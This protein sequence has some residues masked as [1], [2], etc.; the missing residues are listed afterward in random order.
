MAVWGVWHDGTFVFSTAGGSRKARNL[1]AEPRCTVT[2]DDPTEAV[3]VEGTAAVHVAGDGVMAA[4]EEK[5]G[6]A[7]PDP[8][9]SPLIAVRPRVVF[10]LIE[11]S[12]TDTA[13][14]WTFA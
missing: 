5:Y 11:D 6:S 9:T 2:T 13:T 1:A 12:F 3:V 8:E 4:Y 10:G 14:R 7:P